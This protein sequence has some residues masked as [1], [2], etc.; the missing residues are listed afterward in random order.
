MLASYKESPSAWLRGL[1]E[2]WYPV[3]LASISMLFAFSYNPCLSHDKIDTMMQASI[4]VLAIA[5]GFIGTAKSILMAS[6]DS[7]AIKLLKDMSAYHRLIGY[8][9]TSIYACFIGLG[10]STIL[11]L[12]KPASITEFLL[13]PLWFG[14][15][16]YAGFGCIRII[17]LFAM[18]LRYE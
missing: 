6:Q 2:S 15:V 12:Y 1:I 11:L 3:Y 7:P 5:I 13:V 17:R 10:Y 9:M 4:T 14:I 16:T 18:I 8:F